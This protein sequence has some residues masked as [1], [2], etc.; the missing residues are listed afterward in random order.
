M[1]NQSTNSQP[2]S[3]FAYTIKKEEIQ[4]FAEH[5]KQRQLTPA[6]MEDF[7]HRFE[8]HLSYDFVAESVEDCLTEILQ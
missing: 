1:S 2:E 7:I 5:F 8:D 4:M 6:E 3:E